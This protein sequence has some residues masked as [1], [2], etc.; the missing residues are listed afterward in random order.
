MKNKLTSK[1]F[2]I[3]YPRTQQ[4]GR[5]VVLYQ[6]S[7][8]HLKIRVLAVF[9]GNILILFSSEFNSAFG[10]FM[11]I[12]FNCIGILYIISNIIQIFVWKR[13]LK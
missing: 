13:Y 5:L 3:A 7:M 8:R 12:F 9:V 11:F 4:R 1:E 10:A 6:K 2:K